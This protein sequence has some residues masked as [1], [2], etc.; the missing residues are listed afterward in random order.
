[1]IEKL[2]VR[3]IGD[4]SSYRAMMD[5]ASRQTDKFQKTIKSV[6]SRVRAAGQTAT[7]FGRLLTIGLTLPLLAI[8]A[9]SVRE[10]A[11]FDQAMTQ[12]TSIMKVTAQETEN[13]RQVALSLSGSVVQG[14]SD[15]AQSYFF[16]ASAGL[17]AAQSIA[18]LPQVAAFA[19]AGAFDMTLATDLLTDAQSALGLTSKDAAK[20]LLGMSQVSD[21][22]VKA[23]TLANASVQQFSEALTNTAGATLKNFNKSMEE[24]VAVLAAYADQGVKANIAGTNLT[25]VTLLLQ[26]AA[27]DNAKAHKKLGFAVFDNEGKMNNYANIIEQLETITKGMSDELKSSTLAQLGFTA[28][29]QNAILPLIGASAKIKEYEKELRDAGGTT[30]KVADRQM[31]SFSNQMSIMK[32]QVSTLAIAI[33]ELLAPGIL[34]FNNRLKPLIAAFLKFDAATKR[35]IIGAAVILAA[36]GPTLIFFG[37]LTNAVL[38]LSGVAAKLITI[39]ILPLSL[40][41]NLLARTG[42]LL[43]AVALVPIRLAIG[44]LSKSVLTLLT[45]ALTPFRLILGFLASAL[46]SVLAP[47]FSVIGAILAFVGPVV[48]VV[49][50]ILG[51]ITVIGLMSDSW[52]GTVDIIKAVFVAWAD[53]MAA[54]ARIIFRVTV[55][56]IGALGKLWD[57]FWKVDWV[58]AMIEGFK[59][60]G[61]ALA[62]F[63]KFALSQLKAIFTGK[64]GGTLEDFIN[65]IQKDLTAGGENASLLDTVSNI[66]SE[67]VGSLKEKKSIKDAI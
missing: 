5:A 21:V 4:G 59:I 51:I 13:M 61:K 14:P 58:G 53:L 18:A 66:I 55:A 57:K 32:N 65:S 24:G 12:S 31:R 7:R 45:I 41:F 25:R 34:L 50:A 15:L 11:R 17:D 22:L 9:L 38:V 23:N 26:K 16:L 46:V 6:N 62:D 63:G 48:V 19:T 43:L 56:T 28:R 20:N 1:M 10:F 39:A 37:L 33:G 44:L 27:L 2:L 35:L 64:R 47:I 30:G 40:A 29:V 42:A 67:E 54:A 49:A 8:G 36:L 60:A 52:R 3:L